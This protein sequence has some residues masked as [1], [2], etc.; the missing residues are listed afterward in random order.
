MLASLRAELLVLRRWRVAWALVAAVPVLVFLVY[1]LSFYLLYVLTPSTQGGAGSVANSFNLAALSPSSFVK[2]AATGFESLGAKFTMILGAL[3]A[4]G[5]WER[6]TIRSSLLAGPGRLRVTVGQAG[7]VWIAVTISSVATFVMAAAFSVLM[8]WVH[9]GV[10]P[11]GAGVWP[12]ASVVAE[13]L[14]GVV[15]V[16]VTYAAMGLVVGTVFRRIGTAVVA[17]VVWLLVVE[18]VVWGLSLARGGVFTT[19]SNH[20]PFAGDVGLTGRFGQP[21]GGGQLLPIGP[22]SSVWVVLAYTLGSVALV[23]LILWF[24]DVSVGRIGGVRLLYRARDVTRT[25]APLVGIGAAESTGRARR[26][27]RYSG[28]G[29]SL[30]AELFAVIRWPV[31][32]ALVTVPAFLTVYQEYLLPLL[33]NTG[34]AAAGKLPTLLPAQFAAAFLNNLPAATFGFGSFMLIGALVGGSSW[35]DGTFRTAL[36]QRP[37]R[38]KTSLGQGLAVAVVAAVGPL[39]SLILCGATS[40]IIALANRHANVPAGASSFP[41]VAHLGDAV[42]V[43]LIIA[44]A[45]AEIGWTLG[46]LFRSPGP[47]MALA[48]VWC[49]ALE[50]TLQY[51]IVPALHGAA[52]AVYDALPTAATATLTFLAGSG[53]YTPSGSPPAPNYALATNLSF[54]VLAV[55][56]VVFLTVPPLV[57]HRRRTI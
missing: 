41:S 56:T 27:H 15:L 39:I 19:I 38:M 31:I 11:P 53:G 47:A 18:D 33:T 16:S 52:L 55:Y 10:F 23:V 46:T 24:R 36:L 42:G 7:A 45:Y 43:A 35:A 22:I 21:G 3:V 2:V 44:V 6:G 51:E 26:G 8:W 40:E 54:V 34:Y 29:A 1:D 57:T 49:L 4:A 28:L 9:P 32:L 37:G 17:C 50:T 30:R 13:A 48:L 12:S 20:M 14:G 5:D 25:H